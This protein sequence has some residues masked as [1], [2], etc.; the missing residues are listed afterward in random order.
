[1]SEQE[2]SSVLGPAK[3]KADRTFAFELAQNG[4]ALRKVACRGW[5]RP[6]SALDGTADDGGM[7]CA[8]GSAGGNTFG[9]LSLANGSRGTLRLGSDSFVIAPEGAGTAV[10][11]DSTTVAA[12]QYG[13][14]RTAWLPSDA[15]QEVQASMVST[16]AAM[17]VYREL[18]AA[19]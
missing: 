14:P 13:S 18:I 17:V 4:E 6:V 5:K 12:W 2:A 16:M 11:K 19:P 15:N 9:Q 10:R 1:V 3:S 8:I 7:T